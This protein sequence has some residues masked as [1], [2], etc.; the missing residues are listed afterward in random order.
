MSLQSDALLWDVRTFVY[1]HIVKT[2]QPPTV[3]DTAARFGLSTKDA[4]QVY[5]ALD[6][7]HAFFLQPGSMNI[8]IANPFSA[9]ETPFRVQAGGKTY[10]A[11]C[12]WDALGIPAAL[13][14]A[15]VIEASFAGSDEPL[16]LTVQNGTISGPAATEGIVAHVLVPFRQWYED[17]TFT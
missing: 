2:T 3:N 14:G 1:Q 15:A 9:V 12:A 11:N 13:Q 7:Q 5:A 8:L 17:M 4:S 16:H 6:A 10:W